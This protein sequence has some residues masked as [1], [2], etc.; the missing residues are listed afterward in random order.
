MNA[1]LVSIIVMFMSGVFVGTVI[2]GTRI[3]LYA[4]PVRSIRKVVA[5]IE[6][7]IWCF[8]GVCT[9][10]FLF[11]VKGGQWRFIDPLAQIAGI[12]CYQLL[13]QKI[14][15]F[16]GRLLVNILVKPFIYVGHLFVK[17]IRMIL[18]FI[19]VVIKVLCMPIYRIYI[20]FS[21]NIFQKRK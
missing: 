3:V 1:Q 16:I 21:A 9:F 15:R 20:K 8:L 5:L 11:L 12:L 4:I 13:F 17:M 19:F 18:R 14:I 2:D 10:Y 6:W 7:L